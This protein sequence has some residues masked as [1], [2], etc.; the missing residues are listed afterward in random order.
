MVINKPTPKETK[1]QQMMANLNWQFTMY[2]QF[3]NVNNGNGIK[4]FD[5]GVESDVGCA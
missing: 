1:W 3:F 4:T 5:A 2:R